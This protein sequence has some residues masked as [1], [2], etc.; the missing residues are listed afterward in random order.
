VVVSYRIDATSSNMATLHVND[1]AIYYEDTGQDAPPIVFSHGLLWNSELFA[2]QVAALKD[3]FRCIAYDHRGQ[4][5]SADG[6]GRAIGIDTLTNDAA[7]LIEGLGLGQVH[8]CGLSLGGI[9]GMRLAIA[10]PGLIKSLI[11]LSTTA[12]P[13]PSKLKYKA[14]NVVARFFG[15][16]AVARAVMPVLHG[17]TALSDPERTAERTTW[18]KQLLSN[19]PTIWRAVNGALERNS[20]YTELGKITAPTLVVVGDEDVATAPARSERIALAIRGARLVIIPRAGHC[21]TWEQPAA[22]T[23][24]IA[25]FLAEQ[26]EISIQMTTVFSK[27][28]RRPLDDDLIPGVR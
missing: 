2:P 3:C 19:R 8:F 20:I 21:L 28:R 17:K 23:D 10:R 24:A 4:G 13:E 11:L 12:D 9:V 15:N 27:Q 26:E 6:T 1:A 14:M 18:Q 16:G 22:V 25:A 7:S 5:K